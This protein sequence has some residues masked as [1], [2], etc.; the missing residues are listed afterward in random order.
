MSALTQPLELLVVWKASLSTPEARI[1]KRLWMGRWIVKGFI[2][3]LLSEW[4]SNSSPPIRTEF[5]GVSLGG[6]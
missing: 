5:V 2:G 4:G 3:A 1:S 6:G